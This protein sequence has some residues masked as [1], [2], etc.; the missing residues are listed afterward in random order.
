MQWIVKDKSNE[1]ASD[2][3]FYIISMLVIAKIVE[4]F[5]SF[6]GN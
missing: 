1:N 2:A 4:S 3:L 5:F 6:S